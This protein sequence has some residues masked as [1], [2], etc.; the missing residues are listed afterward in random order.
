MYR[1]DVERGGRVVVRTIGTSLRV[2]LALVALITFALTLLLFDVVVLGVAALLPV[3]H[4]HRLPRVFE[5]V[6]LEPHAALS[7]YVDEEPRGTI[8]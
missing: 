6:D 3:I 2:A 1:V 7:H 5:V 8:L 4:R